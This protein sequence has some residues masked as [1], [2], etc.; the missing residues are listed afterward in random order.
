MYT[1]I[2]KFVFA[3]LEVLEAG[4]GPRARV[5]PAGLAARGFASRKD[6]KR[7]CPGALLKSFMIEFQKSPRTYPFTIFPGYIVNVYSIIQ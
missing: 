7:V 6:S 4:L 2:H 1:Y 3:G 5:R